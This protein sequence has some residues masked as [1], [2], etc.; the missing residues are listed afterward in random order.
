[1]ASFFRRAKVDEVNRVYVDE[2]SKEDWID[3]KLELSKGDMN[4]LALVGPQGKGDR[5]GALRMADRYFELVVRSWSFTD[6]DG[7]AVPCTLA[8]FHNL[9]PEGANWIDEQIQV[10]MKETFG[11]T[12][13]TLED[14]GNEPS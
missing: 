4:R 1:M 12:D 9:A 8:E 3:L 6:E 11:V 14:E 5:E 7:E 10:H 2:A 13:E